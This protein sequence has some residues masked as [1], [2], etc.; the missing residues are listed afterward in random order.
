MEHNTAKHFVL[1]LGSVITL[2]L[3]I[4][5]LLVLV[6]AIINVLIP[7]P[8]EYYYSVESSNY[9]VRLGIA[10]LLVFFP[11][12]LYLTRLVNTTKRRE[13]VTSYY[14]VTK[15]LMYLSL[16]IGGGI[17]LGD[18]VTIILTYLNGELTTR[19]ILKALVLLLVVAGAF[20]YYLQDA[21]GYW[22]TKEKQSALFGFLFT[23]IVL[24]AIVSG[25]IVTESPAR[26]VRSVLMINRYKTYVLYSGKLKITTLHI[27]YYQPI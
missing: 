19:F 7:D 18:L 23:V 8:T 6:F 27:R 3:S 21:K 17:L 20:Y 15:W 24:L 11:A 13:S 12:Y 9:S 10:M 25:F 26:Y 2:Y 14:G 22:Y 5:F 16:L 4:S 1:Q